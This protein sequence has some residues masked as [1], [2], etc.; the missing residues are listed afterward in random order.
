MEI[1]RA[2]L[3]VLLPATLVLVLFLY[4]VY[5]ATLF[6]AFLV[7][8]VASTLTILILSRPTEI[9]G[10]QHLIIRRAGRYLDTGMRGGRFLLI[11]TLDIP[12]PFDT[13]PRTETPEPVY[14]FT[15]E[16]V[17]LQVNYF[18]L[19][20]VMDPM[21]FLVLGPGNV[22]ATLGQKAAETLMNIVGGMDLQTVLQKRR[23]IARALTLALQ[24]LPGIA[25]WGIVFADAGLGEIKIPPNVA[26]AMARQVAAALITQARI[27]ED[28]GAAQALNAM[29]GVVS[30]P[31]MLDRALLFQI[32]H[33]LTEAI[34]Q[35][36]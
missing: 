32:L 14:C 11:R 30:N 28:V 36:K 20:Q 29:Q 2:F 31:A 18:F 21:K 1:R 24:G 8:F 12:I 23:D 17:S 22:P 26:E 7:S 19:W 10:Y 4:F 3:F 27:T 33:G 15:Q 13:R 5:G 25:G 35:R 34:A 16:G 6:W 9:E